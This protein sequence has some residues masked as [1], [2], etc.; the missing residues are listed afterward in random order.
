[1][2]AM[3]RSFYRPFFIRFFLQSNGGNVRSFPSTFSLQADSFQL[4]HD[5]SDDDRPISVHPFFPSFPF[6][7]I[8]TFNLLPPLSWPLPPS[9]F[10]RKTD[11]IYPTIVRLYHSTDSSTAATLRSDF[12]IQIFKTTLNSFIFPSFDR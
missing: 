6:D 2:T 12:T 4:Q 10:R 5:L 11:D 9:T 3:F 8:T 7:T 1:M